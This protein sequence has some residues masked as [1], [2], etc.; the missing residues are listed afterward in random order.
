M[1]QISVGAMLRYGFSDA[2]EAREDCDEK[3]RERGELQ[4]ERNG[5]C[6]SAGPARIGEE[7]D[8][9]IAAALHAAGARTGPAM[10]NDTATAAAAPNR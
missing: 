5:V 10:T 6:R 7:I 1:I 8:A 2:D 3:Q 4:R 9:R